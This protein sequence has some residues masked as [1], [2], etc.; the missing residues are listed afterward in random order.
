MAAAYV[1]GHLDD[2][3]RHDFVRHLD[4]CPECQQDL[5][6]L[7][8]VDGLISL[9]APPTEYPEGLEQRAL[10]AVL[11]EETN[12]A[13]APAPAPTPEPK[14]RRSWFRMPRLLPGLSMAAAAVA[15]VV[16]AVLAGIQFGEDE[17]GGLGQKGEIELVANLQ[18]PGNE[19]AGLTVT[20]LATGREIQ[21]ETTTLPIL[22]TGEFYEL[23]FVGPGDSPKNRN[24]ISAG[25]FHPDENGNTNVLLHAAVDP[26]KLPRVEVT[27]EPRADDDPDSLGPVVLHYR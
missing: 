12:A 17:D 16:I 20:K 24:R 8:Q 27:A 15:V 26:A 1:T 14:P 19:Q 5:A 2:A 22:P 11:R 3:E 21:F 25:T 23:W 6:E 4:T 7:Q 13:G 18:G 10:A 9:A